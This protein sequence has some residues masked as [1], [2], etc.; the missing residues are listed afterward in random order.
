MG[1][2]GLG[3]RLGWSGVELGWSLPIPFLSHSCPFISHSHPIPG[4]F[5]VALC[6]RADLVRCC[7]AVG[8]L[9][10][11][12][13]VPAPV[14]S[15]PFPIGVQGSH[16]SV[17]FP[18]TS[19]TR[20]LGKL[21]ICTGYERPNL[22]RLVKASSMTKSTKSTNSAFKGTLRAARPSG[23][24]TQ[25]DRAGRTSLTV[26]GEILTHIRSRL[27]LAES[28]CCEPPSLSDE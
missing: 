16:G 1:R 14:S 10:P 6:G 15:A 19:P 18:V 4:T 26:S 17:S 7:R 3:W 22:H 2:G 8:A 24:T 11:L 5:R 25:F 21:H 20:D 9:L 13:S 28:E 27:V 12:A 23:P